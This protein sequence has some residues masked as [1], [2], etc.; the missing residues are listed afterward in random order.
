MAGFKEEFDAWRAS[1]TPEERKLFQEQEQGRYNKAYRKSEDF[2]KEAVSEEK[3]EELRLIR[4]KYFGREAKAKGGKVERIPDY[5]GLL[6]KAGGKVMDSSLKY[7]VVEI[8]R[9]AERRY[10]YISQKIRRLEKKGEKFP[11]SSPLEEVWVLQ[12]NDTDSHEWVKQ[13]Y[14]ALKMD[15]PPMGENIQLML[16]EVM[17][18]QAN[19]CL[20]LV[21]KLLDEIKEEKGEA[22]SDKY[23]K[24]VV[25]QALPKVFDILE[26]NYVEARDEVEEGANKLK[27]FFRSQEKYK[28]K[29]LTKADVY[30]SF[31]DVVSKHTG[32]PMP[33]LDEE[34]LAEMKKIPAVR[35]GEFMHPWGTEDLLYKSE[36]IDAFGSKYLLG[37]FKTKEEA[38]QA[39]NT[40]NAEYEDARKN[41]KEEMAQWSKQEQARLDKEDSTEGVQKIRKMIEEARAAATR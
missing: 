27:N 29:G 16:P 25:A 3:S 7:R 15:V 39:F 40:W 38:R 19:L 22:E 18:N 14:T 37:I 2:K 6:K 35:E 41:Q 30:K 23:R 20:L 5:D 26:K 33:P 4:K 9:Q 36:A 1:L 12:N 11:Q 13:I 8:D 24:E 34:V 28:D 32:E 10:H 21:E 17:I 31:W